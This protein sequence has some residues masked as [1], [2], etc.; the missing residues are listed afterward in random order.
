MFLTIEEV[1]RL[2]D[3]TKLVD[4]FFSFSHIPFSR[5]PV[6]GLRN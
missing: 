4:M 6:D 5:K 1:P 2:I 3:V